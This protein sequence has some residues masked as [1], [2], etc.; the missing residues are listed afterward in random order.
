MTKRD[1]T[2]L[3]IAAAEGE[4]LT[5]VQLQK[6]LFLLGKMKPGSVGRHYYKFIPYNYGPFD[7]SIYRDAESL[8]GDG[9]V[10]IQPSQQGKWVQYAATA[11]GSLIAKQLEAAADPS[12]A[13]YLRRVVVWV[14]SLSFQDLVKAI[15]THYPEYK[16]NSVFQG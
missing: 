16:A 3:A 5:P 12:A 8:A 4:P 15:Y 7:G 11:R 1:W 6:A 13:D 9:Y 2:L 10:A 14:R